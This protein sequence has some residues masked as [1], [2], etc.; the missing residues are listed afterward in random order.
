MNVD[1]EGVKT[2]FLGLQEDI[3][4]ALEA[5]DGT[6]RFSL[7]RLPSAGGGFG[8]P[9]VLQDGKHIEKA[10][11]QFTHSYGAALPA[12]ASERNP[13]LAGAGFQA[14]AISVIVHPRNPYVPTTHMNLRFFRVAADPPVWHFGGGFDLTPYYGF[15]EDCV[16][17][18]QAARQAGG[19]HYRQMK[20]ACDAYFHLTHRS[21]SRGIGGLFFD[22][23]NEGGFAAS[24]NLTTAIGRA[25]LPAYETIFKCRNAMVYGERE[26]EWQLCRRGRYVEFNLVIDRGTR[27]GLQSGRRIESVLASL[28]PLAQWRYNH[29]PAPGT[30]EAELLSFYL[31][32]RDWLELP[33]EQPMAE[34]R[35][36]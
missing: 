17:W 5:L 3:C 4:T 29:S 34:R 33:I 28:P 21:E 13:Q 11:V 16:H 36:R 8:Q 7:E 20:Q 18:H 30:P 1:I 15:I 19:M 25:F 27:Y 10:A 35:P 24:F 2:R 31:Q 12:A 9:R 6:A 26:R 32:P 22:D 23:W 14:V